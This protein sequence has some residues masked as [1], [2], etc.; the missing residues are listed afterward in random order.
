MAQTGKAEAQWRLFLGG[1]ALAA[2]GGWLGQAAA[3]DAS[4]SDSEY[5]FTSALAP[6]VSSGCVPCQPGYAPGYYPSADEG[7]YAQGFSGSAEAEGDEAPYMIG[8]LLGSSGFYLDGNISIAGGDRLFKISEIMS[9]IP[10]DRLFFSYNGF[11]QAALTIEN[12]LIDVHRYTFGGE[13]TFF[14]GVASLEVRAPIVQGL[15]AVQTFDGNLFNDDAVEFGNMTLVPKVLVSDNG[16]LATSVGMGIN[17]PTARD[18]NLYNGALIIQNDAVHLSPFVGALYTPN[19]LTYAIGYAQVDFGASENPVIDGGVEVGALQDQTLL[20]FD[21]AVG[22]FLLRNPGARVSAIAP[23]LELH[24][25]TTIS[26][27]DVVFTTQGPVG[28][29]FGHLNFLTLTAGLQVQFFDTS[30][31]T[32]GCAV[33]LREGDPAI[34]NATVIHP[35]KQFDAEVLVTFNRLF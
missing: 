24:Y 33:P 17:L 29:L 34:L 1:L 12:R 31:L 18:S 7:D 11:Q 32:V 14:D 5:Q 8:N 15:N 25:T 6:C 23:Q 10:R 2:C 19:D 9:P 26:D 3:A 4:I 28:S 13:K 22:R 27:P 20:H 16:T 30:W 35:D 21:I